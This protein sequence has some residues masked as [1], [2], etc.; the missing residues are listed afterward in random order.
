MH[1]ITC[2]FE[3]KRSEYLDETGS[4]FF[5][6]FM[7]YSDQATQRRGPVEFGL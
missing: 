2:S 6:K 5:A 4:S 3:S 7:P 1:F